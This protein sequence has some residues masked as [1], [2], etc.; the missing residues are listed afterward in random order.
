VLQV[1]EEKQQ[2][3]KLTDMKINMKLVVKVKQQ[4]RTPTQAET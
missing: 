3:P 4:P 2:Q 1:E